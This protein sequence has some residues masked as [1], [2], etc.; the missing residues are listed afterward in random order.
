MDSNWKGWLRKVGDEYIDLCAMYE[1]V[2]VGGLSMGGVLTSLIAARFNPEKI[3]LCAPAF[4]AKDNR[5]KL[6]PFLKFFIKKASTVK[7]TYENDPEYGRAI[8]DY[9]GIEYLE[10]SADLYKLQKLAIK[11]MIFI[12]SQTLTI[13]S[14]ADNLVSFK[15]KDLMDKNLRTQNEYLILEKSS[16]VVTNDV[17]KELVAKKII[18]FL[19][20]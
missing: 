12:K 4:I 1:R 20:D 15:V 11:N 16:H 6:T 13:L 7:K 19:K 18:E 3:F 2:F 17:E 5:I 9:N 10:K 14:K 8:A